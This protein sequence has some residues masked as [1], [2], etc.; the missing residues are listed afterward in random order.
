MR[1]ALSSLGF[2]NLNLRTYDSRGYN[3]G[4][5]YSHWETHVAHIV[6]GSSS[7]G[8]YGDDRG[9]SWWASGVQWT[10]TI[11][12][13]QTAPKTH[14]CTVIKTA[15]QV[16]Q[17]RQKEQLMKVAQMIYDGV[18]SGSYSVENVAEAII[19]LK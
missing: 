18:K 3:T 11:G 19:Y 14:T 12:P 9:M 2:L 6:Y 17:E 7:A 10:R 13:H 8:I 15:E 4:H 1:T 5:E 16:R